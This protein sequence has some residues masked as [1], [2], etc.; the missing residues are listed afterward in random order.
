MGLKRYD[1]YLSRYSPR[2][3]FLTDSRMADERWTAASISESEKGNSLGPAFKNE[4]VTSL[5]WQDLSVRVSD[6]GTGEDKF[7]LDEASGHVHAGTFFPK[8]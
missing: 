5:S 2:G 7:I 6:R 3:H 1:L 4:D 8:N